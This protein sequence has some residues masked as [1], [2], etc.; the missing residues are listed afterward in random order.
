MY[1]YVNIHMYIH[2]YVYVNMYIYIT[3]KNAKHFLIQH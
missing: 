1:V 3:Y 2:M